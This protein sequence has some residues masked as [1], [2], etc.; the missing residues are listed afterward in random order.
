M[1]IIFLIFI[2]LLTS[3]CAAI[4]PLEG[5]PKDTVPPK[6]IRTYPEQESTN[7]FQ[8]KKEKHTI[9]L[10]FDKEIE[11][12]DIYNKLTVT[13]KLPRPKEGPSYVCKVKKDILELSLEVP[14]EENTTYTFNFKDA[15]RDTHEGTPA[16]NPTLTFSTGAQV[17]AMYITGQVK[18]LM[19]DQPTKALISLYKITEADTTHILNSTPDY[20]TESKEDGT[21]RIEHIKQGTYRLCAGQSKENKLTIDA[22]KEPYGFLATPLELTEPIEN[23][24]LYITHANINEFKVQ[25][26][27]P[28]GPYFEISLSKPISTYHLHLKNIPKRLKN[29]ILYTHLIEEG[30]TI[31]VYNT[32]GLLED[33]LLEAKLE[34]GDEMGN[35]IEQDIKIQ[36]KDRRVE[37]APFKYTMQPAAGTKINAKLLQVDIQ[38]SKPIKD[39]QVDKLYLVTGQKEKW[40][41]SP[42]EI[43]IHPHRD[44][45]TIQKKL[46]LTPGPK[47]SKA[48][49]ASTP[50]DE[51]KNQATLQIDKGAFVSVEKELNEAGVFKYL[52]KTSEEC[53][54][55]KGNVITRAAGFIIQLLDREYQVI[56]EI[57]N[58]QYYEFKDVL[59]GNYWVRVL[60]T[61]TKEGKWNFGNINKWTPPDPV[62]VYPHELAIVAKWELEDID[63]VF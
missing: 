57:R 31:R 58:Q 60:V 24:P 54:S 38:F 37:K 51:D 18:L 41:I 16:E 35:T 47:S 30:A 11:V 12:Q 62:I 33:D 45:I 42:E 61:S 32:L 2:A 8:D 20:F 10:T 43:T 44:K 63:F 6:L 27:K 15:I 14:L 3:T 13:P 52:F 29:S 1:E 26:S 36:F 4:Q 19:T 22:S 5:G 50:S 7:S 53:G 9:Q 56:D 25:S 59:P 40:P 55:I 49:D 23:I 17:D 39:I 46:N 48:A 34:A 21:F 28:Q